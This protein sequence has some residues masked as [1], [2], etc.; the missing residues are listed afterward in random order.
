MR[1]YEGQN[2]HRF[3]T[4]LVPNIPAATPHHEMVALPTNRVARLRSS[5]HDSSSRI[6]KSLRHCRSRDCSLR[7]AKPDSIPVRTNYQTNRC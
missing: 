2:V 7:R 3:L 4:Q 1:N 5:P 6:G